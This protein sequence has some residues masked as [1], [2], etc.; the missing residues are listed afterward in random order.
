MNS[1]LLH[2]FV[3]ELNVYI[4]YCSLP[5]ALDQSEGASKSW[6]SGFPCG[7]APAWIVCVS[8]WKSDLNCLAMFYVPE[9]SAYFQCC[10]NVKLLI[11]V[12]YLGHTFCAHCV[13]LSVKVH[14][15]LPGKNKGTREHHHSK[16][17]LLCPSA[18]GLI[19]KHM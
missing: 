5:C 14:I 11:A 18:E 10:F 7:S 8:P 1:V 12:T 3:W 17:Q 13:T 19:P 6:V 2:D 9:L 15:V 16:L 4:K